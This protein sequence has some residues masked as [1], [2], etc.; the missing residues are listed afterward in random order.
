MKYNVPL[1]NTLTTMLLFLS[2]QHKML[3]RLWNEAHAYFTWQ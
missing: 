1:A 2:T 3:N